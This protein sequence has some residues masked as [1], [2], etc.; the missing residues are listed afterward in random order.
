M[1]CGYTGVYIDGIE[2]EWLHG[3][4]NVIYTGVED[5]EDG[6]PCWSAEEYIDVGIDKR[7]RHLY[8]EGPYI[9]TA[10]A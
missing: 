10:L 7:N 2:N 1:S 6:I 5:C 9:G 3:T 4:Y 8:V